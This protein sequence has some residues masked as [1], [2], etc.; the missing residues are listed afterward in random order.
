VPILPGEGELRFCIFPANRFVTPWQIAN[1]GDNEELS[2]DVESTRPL[3]RNTGSDRV[4]G[5]LPGGAARISG[6]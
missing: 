1:G 2:H 4:V 3:F 6:L 5:A